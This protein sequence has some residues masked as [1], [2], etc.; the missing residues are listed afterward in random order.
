MAA[1]DDVTRRW[2]RRLVTRSLD[3]EPSAF[4]QLLSGSKSVDDHV[5][6]PASE[7]VQ[8]FFSTR[9]EAGSVLFFY[10]GEEQYELEEE[11]EEEVEVV[12]E[13]SPA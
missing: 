3:V 11:V 6:S 7:V 9:S 1:L 8:T 13:A 12:R 2:L 4:D 5:D 10:R